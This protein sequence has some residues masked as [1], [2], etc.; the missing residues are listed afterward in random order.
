MEDRGIGGWVERRARVAGDQ[1][2]LISGP[3]RV[4][5]AELAGR[6]R[7]VAHA[8][9]DIGVEHGDRV[10]WLGPNHPA[11]LELLFA[12][13][14]LGAIATPINHQLHHDVITKICEDAEPRV[15]LVEASL[16][17]IEL[18]I[19]S[20]IVVGPAGDPSSEYERLVTASSDEPI[21]EPV[22]LTDPCMLPYTSGTTGL[23]KGILLTHENL[24]WNTFNLLAS[25]DF[26][27]GDVTLAIAPFFRTGG[28]GVNVLPALFQGGTV[29]VPERVEPDEVL[30]LT[31]EHRATVGFGNPALLEALTRS[32]LWREADLSSIRVFLTGGAPVPERLI[33]TY[34]ERGVTFLQG[35]G[36]SEAAPVVAVLDPPNALRK[37]GAAGRPVHFV[38]VRILRP[39]GSACAP[40]EIGELAVRGPNVMAGYW[41]RPDAT[42]AVLDDE[43]WLKTGDAVRM[44]DEGFLFVV[45]RVA[46]AYLSDGDL[47]HPGE[48]ERQLLA[49]PA[50]AEACVAGRERGACAFIVRTRGTTIGEDALLAFCRST[51]APRACPTTVRFIDALPRNPG[52]K[53]TRYL[54]P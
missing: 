16:A 22:R 21:D 32:P 28:T 3:F 6:I 8:L 10:G 2:A 17:G 31:A 49:H 53:I 40:G 1:T 42:R 13:A 34:L 29:V 20:R 48:A 51:L 46:D 9:R 11:F 37:V 45:G 26:R 7:R 5:Y 23:P 30:R 19:S 12:A 25:C 50:V 24:T 15:I 4:T 36:L 52:G 38:D 54:L 33:T 41:R 39:D 35:Y 43:R 44:D 47:V 27:A 14:K 18:P